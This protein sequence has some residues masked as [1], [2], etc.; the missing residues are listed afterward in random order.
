MTNG[1]ERAFTEFHEDGWWYRVSKSSAFKNG[2]I[3][4][5]KKERFVFSTFEPILEPGELWFKFGETEKNALD[6]I[7]IDIREFI[8][9]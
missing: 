9:D 3:A 5:A 1:D 7:K 2:Y 8:N 4:L 6:N